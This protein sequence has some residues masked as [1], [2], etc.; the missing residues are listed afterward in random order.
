M[1][2]STHPS[3]VGNRATSVLGAAVGTGGADEADGATAAVAEDG[4]TEPVASFATAGVAAAAAIGAAGGATRSRSMAS[5]SLASLEEGSA[6]AFSILSRRSL[7]LLTW[8]MPVLAASSSPALSAAISAS[9]RD[10][11]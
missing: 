11:D 10:T 3:T 4:V 1:S 8:L 5:L 6:C 9:S 7:V 2:R